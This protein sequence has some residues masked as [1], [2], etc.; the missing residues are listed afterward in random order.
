MSTSATLAGA[1]PSSAEPARSKPARIALYALLGLL[2]FVL[3]F[4]GGAKVIQAEF[5]MTNMAELHFGTIPTVI[6]GIIELLA[7]V[8]LWVRRYRT[9]ALASFLLLIA[10]GAGAH[11]GFGHPPGRIA[12]PFA[13]A[14]LTFA[15]LWLDRGRALWDFVLR[16]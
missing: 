10:G 12:P 11:W 5:M 3:V 8:G 15:T 4:T 1:R 2:T 13:I 7:A 14:G 16:R 6:I 9:L